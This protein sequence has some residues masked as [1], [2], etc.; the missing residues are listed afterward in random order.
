MFE[1]AYGKINLSLNIKGVREDGYHTLESIFLPINFYDELYITKSDEM[2]FECNRKY[3]RFNEQNTI[4]KAIDLMKKEFN[5]ND[6]FKVV[7]NKQIPM[8][9]G[10]AGGSSDGAA[11]IRILNKMYHLDLNEEKI[12]ELCLKIGA[13]VYFTYYHKPAFVSGIG[14][15]IRFIDIKDD[16]YVL[17]VKPRKGVST[18]ECYKLMNMDSCYHPDISKLEEALIN[19]NDIIQ[20]LGNSMEEAAISLLKDIEDIKKL[21]IENGAP[22]ALM[23]GSGSSVFTISKD[24]NLIKTI[25]ESIKEKG[26]FIRYTK[27][28]H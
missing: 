2:L 20:F 28:V 11:T 3:I 12:K 24:I 8:Q 14:D 6:N 21:L 15:E 16:Y 25:Y 9:A 18:K 22:F 10:L 5:I 26:Y 1:K 7:L 19:G 13:D 4:V 17:I 23:S 27:I